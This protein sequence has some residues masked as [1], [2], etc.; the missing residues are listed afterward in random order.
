MMSSPAIEQF[1]ELPDHITDLVQSAKNL[2]SILIDI[3]SSS[4]YPELLEESQRLKQLLDRYVETVHP[5]KD[6]S[7]WD[8][9][10]VSSGITLRTALVV[11]NQL[12]QSGV[13][14]LEKTRMSGRWMSFW[15]KITR[16]TSSLKFCLEHL[17]KELEIQLNITQG[18]LHTDLA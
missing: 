14:E 13:P 16:F 8:D 2:R 18:I 12:I 11:S 4:S 17:E 10:P 1:L 3:I 15:R 7:F 9:V 6:W 5:M